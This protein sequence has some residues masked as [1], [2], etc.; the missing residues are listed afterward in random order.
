MRDYL[1]ELLDGTGAL[2]EELRRMERGLSNLTGGDRREAVEDSRET[3]GV[4]G[5]ERAVYDIEK[6][7]YRGI[8]AVDY[9]DVLPKNTAEQGDAHPDRGEGNELGLAR[10]PGGETE[11]GAEQSRKTPLTAQLE[12]LDRAVS[13][14]AGGTLRHGKREKWWDEVCRPAGLKT[15]TGFVS[16]PDL[17][18]EVRL[19]AERRF[20]SSRGPD[21]VEQ[22]DR[23]FR[24]DSRRYDGGFYLY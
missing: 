3:E 1:E 7:V 4:S 2:L 22:A 12:R 14:S 21:W 20:A 18:G 5:G 11:T 23:A 8:N 16:G 19:G 24:R 6:R 13:A 10:Q 9:T 17:P 15:E